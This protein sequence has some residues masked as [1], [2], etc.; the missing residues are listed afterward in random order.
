MPSSPGSVGLA[1]AHPLTKTQA[2]EP[3]RQTWSSYGPPY[4]LGR[5]CLYARSVQG[6]RLGYDYYD[7]NG[8]WW[9]RWCEL[10]GRH[11]MEQYVVV[12]STR[13]GYLVRTS[14]SIEKRDLLIRYKNGRK[15]PRKGEKK[16]HCCSYIL[17]DIRTP[18]EICQS[19]LCCACLL[20][21]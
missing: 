21:E 13:I 14:Y 15:C 20:T 8:V 3:S 6:E 18:K 11:V 7:S 2:M 5:W 16:T 4:P 10:F 19:R 17:E 12:A 1:R 9:S